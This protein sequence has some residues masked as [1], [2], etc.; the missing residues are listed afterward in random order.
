MRFL[1][2][3]RV[4]FLLIAALLLAVA[5]GFQAEQEWRYNPGP[6]SSPL[7]VGADYRP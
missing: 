7:K 1:L 2:D 4:H 5:M 3:P 6:P